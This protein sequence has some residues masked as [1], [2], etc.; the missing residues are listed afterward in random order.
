MKK[1]YL[2]A[3]DMEHPEPLEKAIAILRTMDRNSCLYMIHRK[4]PLP[5]LALAKEHSLNSHICE[6]NEQWHIIISIDKNI[7]LKKLIEEDI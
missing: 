2:D 7:D 3:R 5:L 4:N 1:I 6:I